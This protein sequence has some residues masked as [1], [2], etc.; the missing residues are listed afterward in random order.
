MTVM[1][2]IGGGLM[3]LL[4]FW[5][6][7]GALGLLGFTVLANVAGMEIDRRESAATTDTYIRTCRNRWWIYSLVIYGAGAQHLIV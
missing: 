5:A 6:R 4:G 3:V 2:Q 1:C 7:L